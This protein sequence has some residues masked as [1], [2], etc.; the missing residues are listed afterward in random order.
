MKSIK[1]REHNKVF[2]FDWWAFAS[3]LL[4]AASC[5]SGIVLPSLRG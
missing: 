2:N 3:T 5:F 1:S 4:L